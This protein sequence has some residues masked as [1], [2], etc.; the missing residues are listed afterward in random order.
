LA[1]V[2]FVTC[3]VKD[4]NDLVEINLLRTAAMTNPPKH[5]SM[6]P[7]YGTA[8][9]LHEI[10]LEDLRAHPIWLW[11]I[12]LQPPQEAKDDAQ[13]ATGLRPWLDG[14]NVTPAMDLPHILLKVKGTDLWASGVLDQKKGK[15]D[16]IRIFGDT[17]P[18]DPADCLTRP[19]PIVYVTVP[20]IA[21]KADLEFH[22]RSRIREEAWLPDS[23]PSAAD[24]EARDNSPSALIRRHPQL[25]DLAVSLIQEAV[26]ETTAAG[27]SVL[28]VELGGGL[29]DEHPE[30]FNDLLGK[31][32]SGKVQLCGVAEAIPGDGI[33][34]HA[35]TKM[36]AFAFG[37]SAIKQEGPFI[38]RVKSCLAKDGE[39]FNVENRRF[40]LLG[41]QW[42]L[43]E[44]S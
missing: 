44:G 11:S 43:D 16:S 28:V 36:P 4:Y 35:G 5:S 9:A 21:G 24:E 3:L 31:A 6:R 7:P 38:Y 41:T 10:T 18:S 2:D 26:D 12:H 20:R 34:R 42:L 27:V 30:V 8:K 1:L 33:I 32:S 17:G 25:R 39:E 19:G 40:A 14:D 13:G 23:I 37:I 15:V 29:A 22:A